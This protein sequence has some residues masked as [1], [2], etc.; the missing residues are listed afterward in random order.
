MPKLRLS[1]M[2]LLGGVVLPA[3]LRISAAQTATAPAAQAP[4]LSPEAA[5][6]QAISPIDIV[7]R[8]QANW[9]EIEIATLGVAVGQAKDA[10]LAR[11]G[12]TYSGSDLVSYARL[13]ALGKQWSN[14]LAASRSYITA[15]GDTKPQLTEAYSF[16]IQSELS[17]DQESD[18]VKACGDMLRSVAYGP[19][20][21][22]IS[23]ATIRYLEFAYT[24]DALRILGTRQRILL[25]LLQA[26]QPGECAI[27]G[28]PFGDGLD[29][30]PHS[31]PACPGLRGSGAVLRRAH[32]SAL[33]GCGH[34]SGD[35][36][37]PASG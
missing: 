6:E 21:D 23:S 13:C 22:D 26:W 31:L 18:A 29:P 11:A 9:S 32:R 12:E 10:C 19:L 7:H 20:A 2:R 5:Y 14:A 37:L 27:A 8:S 34:R 30:A 35:A 25:A 4:L 28:R 16:E 24:G 33:A 15:E 17:L 3:Y 36:V 1:W